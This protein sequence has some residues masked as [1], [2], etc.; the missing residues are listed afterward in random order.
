MANEKEKLYY[1]AVS[2]WAER[3]G[4]LAKY[5]QKHSKWFL[6]A[7]IVQMFTPSYEKEVEKLE[8]QVEVLEKKMDQLEVEAEI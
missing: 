2:K 8:K 1:E 6:S 3:S 4:V 5:Q 7:P